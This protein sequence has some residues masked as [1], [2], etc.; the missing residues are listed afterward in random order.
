[1]QYVINVFLHKFVFRVRTEDIDGEIH[2]EFLHKTLLLINEFEHDLFLDW[3]PVANHNLPELDSAIPKIPEINQPQILA[4]L[5][6]GL[7]HALQ[8]V[9]K[10]N[11]LNRNKQ[12]PVEF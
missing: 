6:H 12:V 11:N 4:F 9:I 1:M 10:Y 5:L 8:A 2:P 7:I 3:V